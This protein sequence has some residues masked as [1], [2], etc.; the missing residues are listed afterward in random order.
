MDYTKEQIKT[1]RESRKE[2]IGKDFKS[3]KGIDVLIGKSER[4]GFFHDFT[5]GFDS[6]TLVYIDLNKNKKALKKFLTKFSKEIK[7]AQEKDEK[8]DVCIDYY[9]F[10]ISYFENG[11]V[12]WTYLFQGLEVNP[13][14]DIET[15]LN[16]LTEKNEEELRKRKS[17][18]Q[19]KYY[20]KNKEKIKAY[21]KK[22]RKE[23][24]EKVKAYRKKYE[25]ENKENQKRYRKENRDKIR[26][27]ERRYREKNRE[28]VNEKT[29]RYY[30]RNKEKMRER[31][32]KYYQENSERIKEYSKKYYLKNKKQLNIS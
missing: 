2:W 21:Q 19:K 18:H 31:G 15:L 25:I 6:Q 28:K 12:G 13:K 27:Y 24:E 8:W 29:R 5:S 1:T 11:I 14:K 26:E 3:F 23:N 4:R 16:D 9:Y 22:Y 17:E 7:E 30:E 20:Q 32:R 10:Y